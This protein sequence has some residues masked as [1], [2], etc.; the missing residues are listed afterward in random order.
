MTRRRFEQGES[1]DR[2]AWF[3]RA[4]ARI[5]ARDANGSGLLWHGDLLEGIVAVVALLLMA[6]LGVSPWLAV[7]LAILTYVGVA[8]LRPSL[9]AEQATTPSAD[10]SPPV[11]QVLGNDNDHQPHA[12]ETPRADIGAVAERYGLTPRECEI[13]PLLAQ[14]LTDREIAERLSISHRTAMNH[15]ANILGKLGLSSRR[16]VAPFI[17][18]HDLA[19][20]PKVANKPE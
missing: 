5:V 4:L 10:P 12:A 15:V 8:L 9:A 11:S 3:G 17:A 2:L 14:R 19:A 6:A 20:L 13:L 18:Q 16:E 1:S 7:P